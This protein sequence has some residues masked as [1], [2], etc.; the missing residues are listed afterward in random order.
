MAEIVDS[1]VADLQV[2]YQQYVDGFDKATAA[3]ERFTRSV[4][5]KSGIG[6]SF[7]SAEVE[8]YANRHKKAVVE[9]GDVAEKTAD[10][11][12]KSV[13][14]QSD[15]EIAA[16]KAASDAVKTAAREKAAAERASAREIAKAQADSARE[17]QAQQKRYYAA[18]PKV[19]EAKAREFSAADQSRDA[20][21][22]KVAARELA[23]VQ[24]AEAKAA[25]DVA[26]A[27]AR[28]AAAV[29]KAEAK[30]AAETYKLAE[31]EK[32]RASIETAKVA[33][34]EARLDENAK[35]RTIGTY[36][37]NPGL[38]PARNS[39]LGATV[40]NVPYNQPSIPASVLNGSGVAAE[41]AAEKE[42]NHLLADQAVLQSNLTA[43]KGRDKAA[44]REIIAELQLEQRLRKA[45]LDDAAVLLRLEER[46]A[47]VASE[48]AAAQ[49]RQTVGGIAKFGE[50][51]G[52]GR[53]GGGTAAVAGLVVGATA[54]TITAA[55][56]EGLEYAE[57]LSN[58]SKQL[59]ITT[60][61]LQIYQTA[62]Q[63]VGLTNDELRASFGQ[64]AANIGKA[65]E[66]AKEQGKL[67]GKD[68]L[69]I[70]LGNARDGYKSLGDL[71]PTI[72]DRFSKI[73][74]PA[75]RAALETTLFGEQGR[76]LD[77]VLSGGTGAVEA[78]GNELERT[79]A[80]LSG[81]AI[82]RSAKTAADLKLL[83][84]QL[85]RQL[86]NTVSQ[87]ADAIR[88]LATS[89]VQGAGALLQFINA[90]QRFQAVS[91]INSGD[92]T[93]AA[94]GRATLNQTAEGRAQALANNRAG[95]KAIR[96]ASGSDAVINVGNGVG[97]IGL[98]GGG[99]LL[100]G[101]YIQNT[102]EAREAARKQ[103]LVQ[104]RD[105][106]LAARAGNALNGGGDLTPQAGNPGNLNVF[107]PDP[108]KVPKGK[109]ADQ[110]ANEAS[111]RTRR[112]NDL[113][114][115]L[116]D[117]RLETEAAQ[118]ADEDKRRQLSR[119]QMDRDTARAIDDLRLRAQEDI[120]KGADAKLTNARL[121]QAIQAEQAVR[122]G[123]I[124][125]IN[126]DDTLS[127]LRRRNAADVAMLDLSDQ[128]L[129]ISG[130][131]AK[132]AKDR[133]DI[134]LKLLA[135]ARARE[136]AE[137]NLV[138]RRSEEGDPSI[139]KQD[140]E[141][142]NRTLKTQDQRFGAQADQIAQRNK[143]PLGD[144]LDSLPRTA[145]QL[146]EALQQA[147]VNGLQALNDGLTDAV[148]KFLKLNGVAGEFLESIIR[149]GI[150]RALIAPIADSLFGAAGGASSSGGGG[151]GGIIKGIG[152]LFGGAR[153]SGGPVS[154]GKAYL[155][156]EN[157]PE[158]ATF[159]GQ[160]TI[161][162]NHAINAA[163]A[164]RPV[165][166]RGGNTV[167]QQTF[168]LDARGGVVTSQLL[169]Q[170]NTIATQRA[171]EAGRASYGA[172]ITDGAVQQQRRSTL[173]NA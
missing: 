49:K 169:D 41:A 65:Q 62:G 37:D 44:I 26:K 153:A 135:N 123:R 93:A 114:A 52:I 69:A 104:R 137:A 112:F 80:I 1:I 84:D 11:V 110:L 51:A 94:A 25:S 20:E 87:N 47:F 22:A 100:G 125:V 139:T 150:E 132:T 146:D 57:N 106:L 129:S 70:D 27:A 50:A 103:L 107:A 78:L 143:G 71:L 73:Q 63:R 162:P 124:Q 127:T 72:V 140:V 67:F 2:R 56:K 171:A 33:E 46:R 158:I 161:I 97:R 77:S 152:G 111:E 48:N 4:P 16:A 118:S 61:D 91:K 82:A 45:G 145:N 157:G 60:R 58:V 43:A 126:L 130:S 31:L 76:K 151:L 74:D 34:R 96:T 167:V 75:R 6:Q 128:M 101:S 19:F 29:Q 102:P 83:G 42:I 170:V 38:R 116:Q 168:T 36:G 163:A 66:G 95:L 92:A 166:A 154:P 28:E 64:L 8:Q 172:A 10:R 24:K 14:S 155:V 89:L 149:I 81:E 131:L 17:T 32:Q 12:K 109:S 159:G 119:E 165:Q 134:E 79:G 142:A 136:T 35:R 55:A 40:P 113:M 53:V 30:S 138:L 147:S 117:Q 85:E 18:G 120:R 86:A 99:G 98:L 133:R 13:K 59:G 122:D 108:K 21:A 164:N 5:G 144:Y 54:A 39:T 88:S 3:H 173:G 7:S 105:I 115:R 15:A 156:G 90:F 141:G 9:I 148:S 23:A 160:G 68:G 121:E